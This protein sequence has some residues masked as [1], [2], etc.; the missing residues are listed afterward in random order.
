MRIEYYDMWTEVPGTANYKP[1]LVHY[2]PD[3]KKTDSALLIIPGS[4]YSN[5]PSKPKQEGER[6]A[7]VFAEKGMNV[8]VLVYRVL[9]DVYPLPLLD[10]RRAVRYLRYN[11]EKLGIDP[12][13]ICTMGY[14]SGGHLAASLTTYADK[15]E[16]ED[17][18]DIDKEDFVPNFQILCYPVLSLDPNNYFT[19]K[20][21]IK[22]LGD[23][24]DE[25]CD[26]LSLERSKVETVPP[27]FIFH[28]FDDKAVHVAN[29]LRFAENLS[30]KGTP[31]EMHIFPDG[32][33]GI[34]LP[35]DDRKELN[36]DKIWLDLAERWLKY[37]DFFA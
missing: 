35:V 23:R 24:A 27:T 5:N 22:M 36:H 20:G 13:R 26:V 32:G 4:G 25:L 31:V 33:H 19:H 17:I 6:V 8:F 37:N 34:G 7:K 11:A 15:M 9:P 1:H 12:N 18:D 21:S 30:L 10:G 14:S 29:S 3:E 16:Y 28:N 2:I